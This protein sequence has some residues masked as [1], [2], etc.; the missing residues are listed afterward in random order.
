MDGRGGEA[1]LQVEAAQGRKGGDAFVAQQL[2]GGR[3][4]VEAELQPAVD[5]RVPA[6]GPA[7]PVHGSL[8]KIPA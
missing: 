2:T 8:H 3:V 7:G 1:P 4:P 5:A 6:V